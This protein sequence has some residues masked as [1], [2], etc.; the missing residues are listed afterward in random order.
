MTARSTAGATLS[1]SA[2]VPATFDSTGYAALTYTK[3]GEVTNL[4]ELG[5][6]YQVITH[7]PIDTAGDVKLKGGYNEGALELAMA[8]DETDAGQIL[9]LAALASSNNY[10]FKLLYPNGKIRYFQGLVT[11]F[12]E[13]PGSR[14]QVTTAAMHVEIT[15]SATGVGIVRV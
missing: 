1:L 12:K 15:T 8:L 6:E 14:D 3:L 7:Q 10:A 13:N 4:G 9:A 11:K 2:G 5:R